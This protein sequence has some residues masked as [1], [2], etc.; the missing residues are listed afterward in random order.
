LLTGGNDG[1]EQYWQVGWSGGRPQRKRRS[2]VSFGDE[3][4]R[5]SAKF[6]SK[7]QKILDAF[8]ISLEN[9]H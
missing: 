2:A 9:F 3:V 7:E 5:R 1:S 8:N 6:A 4:A